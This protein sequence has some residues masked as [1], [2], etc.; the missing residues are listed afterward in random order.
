MKAGGE[1]VQHRGET[2][3]LKQQQTPGLTDTQQY[4]Q[5]QQLIASGRFNERDSFVYVT[6]LLSAAGS[7]ATRRETRSR[8]VSQRMAIVDE[9]TR[10]Q[11][12]LHSRVTGAAV[13]ASHN[14]NSSEVAGTSCPSSAS[15]KS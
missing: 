7:G 13:P 5:L 2:V 4:V 10:K 12:Q 9:S 6:T 11:V 8:K 1:I 14:S 15:F 3:S